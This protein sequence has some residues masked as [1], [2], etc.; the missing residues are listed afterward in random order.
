MAAVVTPAAGRRRR[1]RARRASVVLRVVAAAVGA[2]M[3]L[4]LAH[5]VIRASEADEPLE[6]VLSDRVGGFVSTTL[7][8][9]LAVTALNLVLGVGMAWL[10]ERTDLPARRLFGMAAA[11]PLVVPTYVAALAFKAAFGPRGLLMDVPWLV[12]FWGAT[13][14]LGLSTYPYVYLLARSTLATTDPALEEASR[15]LGDGPVSTFRRVVVPQLRPAAAAGGLLSFLYVLSD[16][17]AV[18]IL[19]LDTV[20]RGIFLEYRSLTGNRAPA[21]VLGVVLVVLTLGAI[22]VE[23]VARGRPVARPA[24]AGARP[25]RLVPLGRWK[26]PAVGGVVA[27]IAA[28]VALPVGVLVYW[29]SVGASRSSG[30]ILRE[31][32]A[33]SVSLS[34]AAAL[35]AVALAVPVAVLGVRHRSAFSRVVETASFAG[36]ALPGLVV[37]LAL[38]FFAIRYT[39]A[40]Y[41]TLTLV[42]V[43]YV[44][45]F[46]PEALGAVRS[47]LT[48]VDPALEEAA[49]SLGRRRAA[50]A[51]TVTLP[52]VRPG[53]LAGGA[54]VFLTA[55]KELPATILLRPAG[56]DTLAVRVWTGASEGLYAQAAPAALLLVGVSALV[57][58]PLRPSRR[59]R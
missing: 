35:L 28:G 49:R 16:F 6:L 39:P 47:A 57:L 9:A 27:V 43:A 44:I 53:L 50:V 15:A 26:G 7:R 29:A 12:G 31:A 18:S 13:L 21:A 37:G 23:R 56:A 17:G 32:A 25:A 34:A 24:A 8:L 5:L 1:D 52:L 14:A 10:V 41:Q 46:L 19:Q 42:V 30:D 45:R 36:Y 4:P 38:V 11:L 58:W 3:V 55:M 2:A 40:I 20:T 59:V 54:L 33:T 22:A 48:R 51:A